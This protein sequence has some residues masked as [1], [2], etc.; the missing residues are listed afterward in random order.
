MDRQTI[1]TGVLMDEDNGS[2]SFTEVCHA[3]HI[4]E[5]VL[6]DLLEHG[7]FHGINSPLRNIN[8]NTRML[9]RLQSALRLQNDLEINLPGVVLALELRDEL[10]ELYKELDI[11]RRQM[12]N[13]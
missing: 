2:I 3:Y 4:S 6:I 11:L 9:N 12:A 5:D 1:I 7:L 8:F 13:L 10:D